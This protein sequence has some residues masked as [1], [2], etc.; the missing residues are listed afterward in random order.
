MI[1]GFVG[2][3]KMALALAQGL[4][5]NGVVPAA[6]LIAYARTDASR[7]RFLNGFSDAIKP[8]WAKNALEAAKVA[9]L[10]VLSV[11]PQQFAEVLPPL[12]EACAGKLVLSIAAGITLKTIESMLDSTSRIV[13]AMPNTPSLVGAGA[14]AYAGGHRVTEADYLL[15][16]KI[17]SAV[18]H[19]VQVEE[20]HMNAVTAL[21]GSG[22][23]YIFMVI[24]ALIEAGV[25]QGL[26]VPLARTL[27]VQTVL[28]A[29][30]MVE[31]TGEE[32]SKL[33]DMVKSPGGTT[34]AGCAVLENGGLHALFTKAV[35]AAKVR[36][37]ELSLPPR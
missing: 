8:S 14:S 35:A 24:E 19:A 7:E 5:K 21:S 34:V 12:K 29:A 1:I 4:V 3:G 26:S 25:E 6:N 15:I 23:A 32:P 11:K 27:A 16:K 18:G 37:D 10:V 2:A 36:A 28:G 20:S 31:V 13:R 17:L 22:P 33:A 9:D 30:K